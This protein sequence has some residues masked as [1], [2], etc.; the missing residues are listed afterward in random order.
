MRLDADEVERATRV[1]IAQWYGIPPAAVDAMSVQ[2]VD[3]TI[4]VMWADGQK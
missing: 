1:R 2:D 4:Q 3:D